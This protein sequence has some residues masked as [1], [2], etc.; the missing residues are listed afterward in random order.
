MKICVRFFGGEEKIVELPDGAKILDLLK[1]LGINRETILVKMD[2]KI[3]PEEE[4][5]RNGAEVTIFH[6]VTG[7]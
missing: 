3:V 4:E 1:E 2:G 6:V 7:G 5:L